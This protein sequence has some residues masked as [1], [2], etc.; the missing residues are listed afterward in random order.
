MTEYAFDSTAYVFNYEDGQ[1]DDLVDLV[2]LEDDE[3]SS[4]WLTLVNWLTPEKKNRSS[5]DLLGLPLLVSIFASSILLIYWSIQEYLL[6]FV[7]DKYLST[8]DAPIYI[9]AS[10]I[11]VNLFYLTWCVRFHSISQTE[12]W[13]TSTP[14]ITFVAHDLH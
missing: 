2:D 12:N 7:L 9:Y 14:G 5:L 6:F 4:V 11:V 13:I 3:P 10:N 1:L 8:V